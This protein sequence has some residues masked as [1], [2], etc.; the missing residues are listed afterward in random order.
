MAFNIQRGF[1]IQIPKI[2]YNELEL[3]PGSILDIRLEK[4]E[5]ILGKVSRS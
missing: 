4:I 3:R 2:E 5:R 1:R